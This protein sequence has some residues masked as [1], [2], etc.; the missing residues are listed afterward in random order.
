MVN[1]TEDRRLPMLRRP[2]WQARTIVSEWRRRSRSRR[3]L[4]V[5]DHVERHN[6]IR[7]F[8]ADSEAGSGFGKSE[9]AHPQRP[10]KSHPHA[11]TQNQVMRQEMMYRVFAW[12]A[13]ASI[14][15]WAAPYV[16]AVSNLVQP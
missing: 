6:L 10:E 15:L 9:P 5:L 1:I 16:Y 14:A 8:D 13:M 2:Y 12:T 7:R 4:A 11:D 3:E